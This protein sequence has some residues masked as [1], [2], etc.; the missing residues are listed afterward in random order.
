MSAFHSFQVNGREKCLGAGFNGVGSFSAADVGQLP[1]T[2]KRRG[3]TPDPDQEALPP[4]PPPR[5]EAP[6]D[7]PLWVGGGRG[8][9]VTMQGPWRPPPIP[10]PWTECKGL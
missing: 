8:P 6:W 10:H 5:G 3:F 7:L 2:G 9:T 4:G 1:G